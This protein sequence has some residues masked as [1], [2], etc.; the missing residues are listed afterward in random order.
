MKVIVTATTPEL[1]STVDP[2]F[3][4]AS[5][6]L[7]VDMRTMEWEAMSNQSGSAPGGAGVQAAQF[8]A[9]QKASAVISGA[10]GPNAFRALKA[11]QVEMYLAGSA[12]TVREAIDKYK[13]EE[14]ECA[15]TPSRPGRPR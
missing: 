12:R 6:F 7:S 4:R 13:A 10:F 15:S 3:G 14:L 5:Y 9:K 11:A 8:V 2:R 1:E